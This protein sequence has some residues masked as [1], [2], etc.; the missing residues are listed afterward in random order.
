MK[1]V[2]RASLLAAGVALAA[3]AAAQIPLTPRALGMGGAYVAVARGQEAL[4]LN[5]ANLALPSSPHWSFGIPTLSA[6]ASIVG[7]DVN[8][9]ID[10]TDYGSLSE[11]R[12]A[13]ILAD[14]PASGTEG[15]V[16]V[17][18]PFAAAQ[19]RNVALGVSWQT[20]GSHSAARDLV[21]LLFNGV[22]PRA[23]DV[24]DTEGFRATW[25]DF[26]AA[27]A[28]RFGQLSVGAT[29]HYYSGQELVRSGVVNTEIVGLPTPDVRVTYAG[30][31]SEG[32]SG[33][34]L[35]LGAAMKPSPRVTLSASISNLLNNFEWNEDL[36]V[37]TVTLTRA[38]YEDGDLEGINDR[39]VESETD[40]D[41]AAASAAVR[42]LADDLARDTDLPRTLRA[43][44][45]WEPRLGTTLSA[46]YQG[47]LEDSRVSGIWE[48]QLGVGAQQSLNRMIAVRAGLASNLDSG[49]LFS[50]GLS[51]GPINLGAARVSDES[52]LGE[53]R[54]GWVA[55]FGLTA[56]SNSTM[57]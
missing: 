43:G 10:I 36:R 4:F 55:T 11:E 23:Y 52:P 50:V 49:S 7:L 2:V 35:D 37:R 44:A 3:P 38:D 51:L 13:E 8:D 57:R 18:V 24:D 27:Y 45:A 26:A 42:E 56:R 15:Q 16:D 5:P 28:R 39:Y 12:Q 6:G 19:I 33:F 32:G 31:R 25:F 53:D 41:G 22:Q 48:K 29:A 47:N 20:T 14:I 17:R 46:S 34:G 1:I 30:V 21:D 9:I 54:S 40:Y